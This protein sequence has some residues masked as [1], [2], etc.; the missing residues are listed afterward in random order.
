M[1][2]ILTNIEALRMEVKTKNFNPQSDPKLLC[3]CGHSDCD[4]RS[5]NQFVLSHVQNI[6]ND[7]GR[8]L[9]ITS[10]GRCPNHPNE[11]HRSK[12]ADHQNRV[13]VDIYYGTVKERNEL[14]V[15]AGRYGATAVAC[16]VNFVH[17]GWR[18]LNKDDNRVRTWEY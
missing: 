17:M 7:A 15:L 8:P 16:G 14:M 1:K 6:R 9:Q 3:T 12:P 10:G 18:N 5:V 13:A 11:L 2:T 4:K